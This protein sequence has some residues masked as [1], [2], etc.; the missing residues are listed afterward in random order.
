MSDGK[1][2]GDTYNLPEKLKSSLINIRYRKDFITIDLRCRQIRYLNDVKEMGEI[3]FLDI[4][5]SDRDGF[6]FLFEHDRDCFF[7]CLKEELEDRTKHEIIVNDCEVV[8][9]Q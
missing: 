5:H 3:E 9:C 6:E 8:K 2:E 7:K 4:S 1:M